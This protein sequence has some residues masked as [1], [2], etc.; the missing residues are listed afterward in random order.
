MTVGT[1]HVSIH[2][3]VDP[4]HLSLAPMIGTSGVQQ[5]HEYEKK[6]CVHFVSPKVLCSI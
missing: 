3:I 4:H 2:K 5:T 1:L 6:Y